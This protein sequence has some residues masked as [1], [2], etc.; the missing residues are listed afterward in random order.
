MGG[1]GCGKSTLA[2][3]CL[4]SGWTYFSDEHPILALERGRVVGRSFVNRIGL[5]PVSLAQFPDLA[6]ARRWHA[7]R[8]KWYVDPTGIAPGCPGDV[9][10]IDVV[11]F[12]RFDA[13]GHFSARRLSQGGLLRRLLGDEYYRGLVALGGGAAAARRRHLRLSLRLAASVPG[14][15]IRYGLAD[16]PA[17]PQKIE[18]LL[19]ILG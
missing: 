18:P 7:G 8:G 4:R 9:C 15:A 12:P 16:V 2:V 17:F 1:S 14:F 19:E 13:T 6:G 10:R 11:L 3:A 5:K